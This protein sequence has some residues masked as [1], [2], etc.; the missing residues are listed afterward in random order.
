MPGGVADD[1]RRLA[2]AVLMAVV[3][4][5]NQRK[6]VDQIAPVLVFHQL[7]KQ[8]AGSLQPRWGKMCLSA[9]YKH[10]VFYHCVVELLLRCGIDGLGK[11]DAGNNGADMLFDLRNLHR[12]RGCL[13]R[14]HFSAPWNGSVRPCDGVSWRLS[15]LPPASCR[16][17]AFR[18]SD[19]R[20]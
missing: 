18:P 6:T 12:L 8:L 14:Y 17:R 7:A 2:L 5:A 15:S 9:D 19:C 11:V 10:H 4:H 20:L 13:R 1:L 16:C 3:E